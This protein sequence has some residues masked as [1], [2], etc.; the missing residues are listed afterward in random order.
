MPDLTL[1][2]LDDLLNE[3]F[4][5]FDGFVCMGT[6]KKTQANLDV[7]FRRWAGGS[8]TCVGLCKLLELEIKKDYSK[9]EAK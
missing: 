7:Y 9:D 5:R 6:Q 8:A 2:S 4:N 3:V 1:I